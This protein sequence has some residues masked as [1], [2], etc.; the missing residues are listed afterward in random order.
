MR[1]IHIIRYRS[2]ITVG[3]GGVTKRKGR[4][5]ANGVL[6]LQKGGG[7]E[8]VVD[9]LKGE[10]KKFPPFKRGEG[11]KTFILSRGGAISLGAA[12]FP[13]CSPSPLLMTGPLHSKW[14]YIF[15]CISVYTVVN[16]D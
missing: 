11:V 1:S 16:L 9:I 6:P 10:G 8:K 12:I 13:F 2:L 15:W 4:G 3:G 7:A 5:V 14:K